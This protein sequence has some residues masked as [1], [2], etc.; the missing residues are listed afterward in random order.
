MDVRLF[1]SLRTLIKIVPFKS[2]L[3]FLAL[4]LFFPGSSLLLVHPSP[5]PPAEHNL[6]LEM[7][8]GG[9]SPAGLC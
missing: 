6:P 7:G 2:S 8:V 5:D 9:L 3:W 4:F 1:L